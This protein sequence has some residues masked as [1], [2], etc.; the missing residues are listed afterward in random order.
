MRCT[1]QGVQSRRAPPESRVLHK[2]QRPRMA[3]CAQKWRPSRRSG[4]QKA[5]MGTR[6]CVAGVGGSGRGKGGDKSWSSNQR[7]TDFSFTTLATHVVRRTRRA[8][9]A[10][11]S[12]LA[13]RPPQCATPAC[14]RTLQH[15]VLPPPPHRLP[16][17]SRRLVLRPVLC[18]RRTPCLCLRRRAP[19]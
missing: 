11:S 19:R 5:P 9:H 6:Q 14:A 17:S 18:S 12:G 8:V 16:L 1:T 7:G 15:G 3:L 10:A 2:K 13:A 4:V